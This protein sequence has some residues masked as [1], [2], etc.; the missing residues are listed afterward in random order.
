MKLRCRC[1]IHSVAIGLANTQPTVSGK[2][3]KEPSC[4]EQASTA[5]AVCGA[6]NGL[7]G[8]DVDSV[9]LLGVSA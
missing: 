4:V 8:V 9:L 5:Q 3:T 1:Y 2:S 6:G 7:G